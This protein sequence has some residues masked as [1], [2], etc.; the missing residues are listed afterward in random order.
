[1]SSEKLDFWEIVREG[2]DEKLPGAHHNCEE[3]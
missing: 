3:G 1:M 2:F